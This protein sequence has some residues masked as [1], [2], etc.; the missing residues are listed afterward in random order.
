M[1]YFPKKCLKKK[2][3][4]MFINP[5][6]AI[7]HIKYIST[8]KGLKPTKGGKSVSYGIILLSSWMI[9]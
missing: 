8:F 1:Q 4:G 3:I 9:T 2:S 6:P 5:N 7:S